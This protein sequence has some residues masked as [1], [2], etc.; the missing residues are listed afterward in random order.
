MVFVTF[1][2]FYINFGGVFLFLLDVLIDELSQ[3]DYTL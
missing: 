2:C 3:A 1:V